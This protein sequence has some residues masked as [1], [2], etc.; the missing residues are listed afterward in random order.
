[1]LRSSLL[2]HKGNA[3]GLLIIEYAPNRRLD[4]IVIYIHVWSKC[5]AC[6]SMYENHFYASSCEYSKCAGSGMCADGQQ[7]RMRLLDPEL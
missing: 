6:V 3:H 5:N 2:R 7:R 1:M 4:S